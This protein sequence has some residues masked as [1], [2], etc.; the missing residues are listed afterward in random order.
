M[1]RTFYK[2]LVHQA[3]LLFLGMTVSFSAAGASPFQAGQAPVPPN[4]AVKPVGT[5]KAI[6][7]NSITLATD[8]GPSLNI[9]VED[10]TRLL[11]TAPGQ[12]DL[13]SATPL[14]LPDLQVGDRMMVRGKPSEDGKSIIAVAA[15]VIKAADIAARQEQD[16]EDWRKRG[17]GGLVTA[18]DQA[19]GTVTISVS[20]MGGNKSLAVHVS[21]DT[22]I[23]RYSPDSVKFDDA[24]PATL[25][26]LREKDQLRA[27]GA[28]SPDGAEMTADE[29]VFGTF[30]NIA[31]TVISTDPA[32]NVVN[33][34]DLLTKKPVALK[35]NGDS[36]LRTLPAM[37]AQR[38]AMRLKGGSP[39]GNANGTNAAPPPTGHGPENHGGPGGPRNGGPP[40]FQQM[41]NRMPTVGLA[42]LQKGNAIMVVATEGGSDNRPT[43]ITLLTGVEPILTAAPD[44]GRAAMLLSPWNL[45]G[46]GGEVAG[47]ANP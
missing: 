45:G 33:V 28:R 25:A 41:L 10:S 20:A 17:V 13:K 27:R 8:S 14:A 34:M 24:T 35:I 15:V 1:P 16:R 46:A 19:G 29:I 43:A 37:V 38:I 2:V 6:S 26:Q 30:R 7:G 9:V 12:K 44:G 4:A 22:M 39:E 36:Q 3:V 40:D 47:G 32:N 21:K 42:D 18:I 11:R 31:G 23:R 5:I